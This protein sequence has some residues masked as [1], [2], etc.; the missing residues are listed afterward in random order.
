MHF[1]DDIQLAIITELSNFLPIAN[2][3]NLNSY[4]LRDI[5][6][7]NNPDGVLS[8][9]CRVPFIH[10]LLACRSEAHRHQ[11]CKFF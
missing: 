3:I 2:Y 8:K 4:H 1:Q 11:F 9:P 5:N 6:R 7:H 10:H